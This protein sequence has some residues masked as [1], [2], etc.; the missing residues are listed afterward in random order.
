MLT[1]PVGCAATLDGLLLRVLPAVIYSIPFYPMTGFQSD[2]AHVALFFCVLAVFSA[3]VGAMS[4]A[5]TVGFGT[6]GKAA[7]I[8]NLVSLICMH[9]AHTCHSRVPGTTRG[10][11]PQ[12]SHGMACHAQSSSGASP[13]GAV[14]CSACRPLSFCILSLASGLHQPWLCLPKL[15][16]ADTFDAIGVGASTQ[17]AVHGLPGEHCG[18]VG[19]AAV[20]ALPQRLL[21]RL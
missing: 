5:I 15:L 8:M 11:V 18:R 10:V 4:M 1:V 17:S 9:L 20:G 6:A 19:R 14:D 13:S 16:H 7:L 21:L 3:T 12:S 2:P